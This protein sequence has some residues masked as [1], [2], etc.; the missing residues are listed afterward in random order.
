MAGRR[1]VKENDG[2]GARRTFS[3]KIGT[4]IGSFSILIGA[5]HFMGW[6]S[7]RRR[8][9]LIR[10]AAHAGAAHHN[11]MR[12]KLPHRSRMD[13]DNDEPSG[14]E[15]N[16]KLAEMILS[17][18]LNLVEINL[19]SEF[20]SSTKGTYQGVTG[21]FCQLNFAAH[22]DDPSKCKS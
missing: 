15:G 1:S 5:L 16:E 18:A 12:K 22:K 20:H 8:G 19:S 10:K 2:K 13:D 6:G 3:R 7:S 14:K 21:A 9:S 17:G 4:V 11:A